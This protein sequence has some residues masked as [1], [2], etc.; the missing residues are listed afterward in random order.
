MGEGGVVHQPVLLDGK[1][2][3]EY[4]R[5]L[6]CSPTIA[7]FS[8]STPASRVSLVRNFLQKFSASVENFELSKEDK[9]IS[10]LS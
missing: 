5:N 6:T 7:R 4:L 9:L 10:T 1:E 3:L 8:R 2:L